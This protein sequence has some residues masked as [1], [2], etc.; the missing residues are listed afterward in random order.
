M[1]QKQT[2]TFVAEGEVAVDHSTVTR[3]LEEFCLR[4]K[5]LNDHS[6]SGRPKTLKS[7]AVLEAIKANLVKSTQTVS[8]EFG[9]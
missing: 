7:E 3:W 4:C 6:K 2:R 5:N 8:G 1:M 9:I